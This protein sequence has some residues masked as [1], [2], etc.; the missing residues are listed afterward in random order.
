MKQDLL[1]L[2][3]RDMLVR[4]WPSG[5]LLLILLL[6]CCLRRDRLELPPLSSD[7]AFSWRLTTYS[8][9]ELL[10][11]MPGDAHPPLYYLLLKGWIALFGDS[12]FALRGLS[13]VFALASIVRAPS[14]RPRPRCTT[15][16]AT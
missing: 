13:V 1:G 7:E 9:A 14:R 2:W 4:R 11:H 5:L 16:T 3:A 8:V 15:A 10:R 12:P 6:A